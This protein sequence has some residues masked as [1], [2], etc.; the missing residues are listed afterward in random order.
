MEMTEER[1]SELRR[2]TNRNYLFWN[3]ERK[4]RKMNRASGTFE[5][6]SKGH[7]SPDKT[8]ERY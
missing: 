8:G 4:E 1:M 5:T 3:T 2:G 7:W 6:V